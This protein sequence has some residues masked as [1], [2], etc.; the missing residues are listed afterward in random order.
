MLATALVTHSTTLLCAQK[1]K[2][3]EEVQFGGTGIAAADVSAL[4]KAS[5][6]FAADRSLARCAL[7]A[8]ALACSIDL[9]CSPRRERLWLHAKPMLVCSIALCRGDFN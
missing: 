5:Q 4:V 9:L 8:L 7:A 1:Y 3:L 6:L 2:G